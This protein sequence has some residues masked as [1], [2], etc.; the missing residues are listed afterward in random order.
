MWPPTAALVHDGIEIHLF[1]CCLCLP[2]LSSLRVPQQMWR[3]DEEILAIIGGNNVVLLRDF[4]MYELVVDVEWAGIAGESFSLPLA[5]YDDGG[6]RA[7]AGHE[8]AARGGVRAKRKLNQRRLSLS[9]NQSGGGHFPSWRSNFVASSNA[10]AQAA[11]RLMFVVNL[12]Q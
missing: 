11:D 1:F 9:A 2:P 7:E 12:K 5:K 10:F 6:G 8:E 4:F 3:D